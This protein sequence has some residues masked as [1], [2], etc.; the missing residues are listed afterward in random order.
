[1]KTKLSVVIALSFLLNTASSQTLQTCTNENFSSQASGWTYSQGVNIGDYR[2]PALNCV[3][4]RGIITPGVG[5]NNP[6]NIQT[7]SFTSTGAT[8]IDLTFDMFVLNANLKCNS[9]KDYPCQ[10]SVDVFYYVGE[11]KYRGIIDMLLPS[12]GPSNI[13]TVSLSFNTG[14][15]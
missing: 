6:C 3:E 12:N 1:M 14:N 10:T 9:W 8:T 4:D 7:P 5:G 13:T 15:N 2:N 11:T